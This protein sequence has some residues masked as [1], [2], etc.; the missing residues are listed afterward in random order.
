MEILS[1]E[2]DPPPSKS[3]AGRSEET[4]GLQIVI[5]SFRT[6]DA[7]DGANGEFLLRN[8]SEEGGNAPSNQNK[9]V[10]FFKP[11]PHPNNHSVWNV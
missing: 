3:S 1:D 5:G 9:Q 2:S 7:A 11:L 8:T 4:S 6:N 10:G